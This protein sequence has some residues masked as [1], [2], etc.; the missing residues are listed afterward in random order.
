VSRS[1][2]ALIGLAVLLVGLGVVLLTGWVEAM[3]VGS[4]PAFRA[5]PGGGP[6]PE[7]R[8]VLA[9]HY[10]FVLTVETLGVATC[11]VGVIVLL[12]SGVWYL[13]DRRIAWG[14]KSQGHGVAERVESLLAGG[15]DRAAVQA[16]LRADGIAVPD[17][18]AALEL[19]W[20]HGPTCPECGTQVR[21]FAFLVRHLRR[22]WYHC[23]Q[24]SW[25]G[26]IAEASPSRA[27]T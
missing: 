6:Q 13:N 16:Q 26:Q 3:L 1:R 23:P 9:D 20:P 15:A 7:V 10:P 4:D 25:V 19:E 21:R 17:V 14:K 12:A 2:L 24:C 11:L 5:S 18:D 8:Q 22:S 27:P